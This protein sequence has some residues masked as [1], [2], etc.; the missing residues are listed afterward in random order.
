MSRAK[1]LI[2]LGDLTNKEISRVE[3]E[4]WENYNAIIEKNNL[5]GESYKNTFFWPPL[6]RVE[7]KSS[8][9]GFAEDIADGLCSLAHE[10]GRS[11]I[12]YSHVLFEEQKI[13]VVYQ[14]LCWNSYPVG[15][16]YQFAL[17]T[18][19]DGNVEKAVERLDCK[20]TRDILSE[21]SFNDD[22]SLEDAIGDI[23]LRDNMLRIGY[24]VKDAF[25][26][27]ELG[28]YKSCRKGLEIHFERLQHY[29]D[30]LKVGEDNE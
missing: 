18:P 30:K 15:Y 29:F 25:K 7:R 10:G 19:L 2:E 11:G 3:R 16:G 21:E 4:N 12:G 5:A 1:S 26:L 22:S 24:D 14:L 6:P 13:P 28:L 17:A 20:L 8:I 23:R 27:D 9:N